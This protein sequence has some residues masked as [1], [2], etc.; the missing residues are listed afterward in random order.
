M[1]NNF[2]QLVNEA[3]NANRYAFE[4]V[5]Q[6]VEA[7]SQTWEKLVSAQLDLAGILFEASAKQLRAWSDVQDFRD[8]LAAQ[9]KLTEEYSDKI[10]K[11]ARQQVAILAGARD[12]YSAWVEQGV[13]NASE[14][15]KRTA[16]TATK[17]AA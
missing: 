10:L 4:A 14:N 2:S 3:S 6:L 5:E 1:Q 15:F 13:D 12:A 16:G 8:I 11:N 7:N 9:A 17:R